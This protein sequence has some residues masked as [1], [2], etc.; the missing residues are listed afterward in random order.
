MIVDVKD[1][2]NYP[3]RPVKGLIGYQVGDT[4]VTNVTDSYKTMFAYYYNYN[5]EKNNPGE[6][7]VT[8]DTLLS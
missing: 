2:Q 3:H 8:N 5:L 6:D 1:I 7:S 4:W